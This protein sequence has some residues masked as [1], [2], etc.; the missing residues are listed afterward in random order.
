ME[1]NART[2]R[3]WRHANR[4]KASSVIAPSRRASIS[5]GVVDAFIASARS[6]RALVA[7]LLSVGYETR[8]VMRSPII[9]SRGYAV[10][11]PA[12]CEALVKATRERRSERTLTSVE[13]DD[14]QSEGELLERAFGIRL[15]QTDAASL[16]D[17]ADEGCGVGERSSVEGGLVGE[18]A[19]AVEDARD[20][21]C[22][23][24]CAELGGDDLRLDTAKDCDTEGDLRV[25]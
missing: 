22:E 10:S 21:D 13:R 17:S 2:W 4:T 23:G 3:A 16:D 7:V 25:T 15:L 18:D 9:E 5:A 14:V 6:A 1:E 24:L 8:V 11:E 19:E 12:Q 20:E